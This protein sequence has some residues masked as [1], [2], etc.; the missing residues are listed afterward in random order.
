M[1][2]WRTNCLTW[3]KR[4][5]TLLWDSE[6][7]KSVSN[8]L[9][10]CST[11]SHIEAHACFLKEA[12][13]GFSSVGSLVIDLIRDDEAEMFWNVAIK[14]HMFNNISVEDDDSCLCCCLVVFGLVSLIVCSQLLF[15]SIT[16]VG[17]LTFESDIKCVTHTNLKEKDWKKEKSAWI[18]LVLSELT[19]WCGA[20]CLLLKNYMIHRQNNHSVPDKHC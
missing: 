11:T 18:V 10:F 1:S 15:G 6:T 20:L 19:D 5:L 14:V 8:C 7:T 16:C 17:A 13:M 2:L 12:W 4:I 9:Y 3:T